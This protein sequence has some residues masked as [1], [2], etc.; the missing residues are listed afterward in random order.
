MKQIGLT[1]D[2]SDITAFQIR[3]FVASMSL[4]AVIAYH[5]SLCHSNWPINTYHSFCK[6]NDSKYFFNLI[7]SSFIFL[8]FIYSRHHTCVHNSSDIFECLCQHAYP[9][10]VLADSRSCKYNFI[11][12]MNDWPTMHN[13]DAGVFYACCRVSILPS[14]NWYL[15]NIMQVV[16]AAT[17]KCV[18]KPQNWWKRYKKKDREC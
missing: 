7:I 18:E 6:A 16:A 11:I 8:L 4:V 3:G 9:L 13:L 17:A 10:F 5:Y 1:Y 2:L 15:T 14:F 12:P